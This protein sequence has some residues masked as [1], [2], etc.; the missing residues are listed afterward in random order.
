[1]PETCKI[2]GQIEEVQNLLDKVSGEKHILEI[3]LQELI[4]QKD[5]MRDQF[6][7]DIENE[8]PPYIYP[9]LKID[10]EQM[11]GGKYVIS[12]RLGTSTL[13]GTFLA[14]IVN[15]HYPLFI[16]YVEQKDDKIFVYIRK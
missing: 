12:Y 7:R 14:S 16:S 1:M 8:C 3:R 13:I 10:V 2:E 11:N 5:S 15:K 6:V 4:E 9:E